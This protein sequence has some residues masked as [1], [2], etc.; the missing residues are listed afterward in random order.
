[1]TEKEG[2]QA[3]RWERHYCLCRVADC[4]CFGAPT[5]PFLTHLTTAL[6]GF[7]SRKCVCS[8]C[9]FQQVS[10]SQMELLIFLTMRPTAASNAW[11]MGGFPQHSFILRIKKDSQY[12]I[13][14]NKD[15]YTFSSLSLLSKILQ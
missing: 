3:G 14:L 8:P 10:H 7:G 13:N 9:T 1:M 11:P 5:H 12:I 4:P 15:Y 6:P 2:G